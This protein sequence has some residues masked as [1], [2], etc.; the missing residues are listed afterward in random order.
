MSVEGEINIGGIE[1][2]RAKLR[3]LPESVQEQFYIALEIL[4]E[5][6]AER[7]RSLAPVRTGRL[8]SSITVTVTRDLILRVRCLVPYAIFQEFGTRY[9]RPKLFLTHAVE[10]N[11]PKI[12]EFIRA[13]LRQAFS[14]VAT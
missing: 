13:G 3:L 12:E 8:V 4:G 14:E 11:M 2:L 6:I 1:E 7:A 10:E 9:T 5:R